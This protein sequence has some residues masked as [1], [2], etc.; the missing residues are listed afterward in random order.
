MMQ[1]M[2]QKRKAELRLISQ[3][4]KAFNIHLHSQN[5]FKESKEYIT[6]LNNA[7]NRN[8]ELHFAPSKKKIKLDSHRDSIKSFKSSHSS[9]GSSFTTDHNISVTE[10]KS[11]LSINRDALLRRRQNI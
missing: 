9:E 10:D 5:L 1:R 7:V 4:A 6:N 3:A 11:D 8:I 2:R